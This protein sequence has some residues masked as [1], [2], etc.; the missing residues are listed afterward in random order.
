MET[1]ATPTGAKQ[2]RIERADAGTEDQSTPIHD[3]IRARGFVVVDDTGQNRAELKVI[4]DESVLSMH[5]ASG[6]LRLTLRA[7]SRETTLNIFGDRK[8]GSAA[9]EVVDLLN[10]GWDR[11]DQ[12]PI[13]RVYKHD[14]A[15]GHDTG[16]NL[17]A[18]E[19]DDGDENDG[20]GDIWDFSKPFVFEPG[21][22]A[23]TGD[24]VLIRSGQNLIITPYDGQQDHL[25]TITET[26]T[27]DCTGPVPELPAEE[28]NAR[29]QPASAKSPETPAQFLTLAERLAANLQDDDLLKDFI[30]LVYLIANEKDYLLRDEMAMTVS[31]QAFYRTC[32]FTETINGILKREEALEAKGL[33]V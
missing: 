16:Y 9:P 24:L 5:D 22:E 33:P 1:T 31:Q 2:T 13:V 14:E 10:I 25:G 12:T 19:D 29:A 18:I 27:W 6:L 7:G 17:A 11:K 3:E 32:D 20:G 28:Q 21:E 23:E 15:T 30:R 26:E 8:Y 4:D